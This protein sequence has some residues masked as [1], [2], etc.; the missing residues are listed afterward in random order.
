MD[1]TAFLN[2]S[3]PDFEF[4]LIS[5]KLVYQK[6]K[7]LMSNLANDYAVDSKYL[8]SCYIVYIQMLYYG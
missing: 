3:I 1:V 6:V 4:L 5:I 8:Y 2:R 7:V